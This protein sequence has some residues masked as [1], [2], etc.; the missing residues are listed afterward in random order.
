MAAH[1]ERRSVPCHGDAVVE[2]AQVLRMN[3]AAVVHGLLHALPGRHGGEL[4]GIQTPDVSAQQYSLAAAVVARIGIADIRDGE[5]RIADA[6]VNMLIL[7]PEAA[8]ELQA[9]FDGRG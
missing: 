1:G 2:F 5:I 3:S 7:L 9:D 8:L 4:H 6:A